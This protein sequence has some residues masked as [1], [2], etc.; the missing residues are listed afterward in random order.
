MDVLNAAI[1]DAHVDACVD[2]ANHHDC[3]LGTL[4]VKT[5]VRLSKSVVPWHVLLLR[6]GWVGVLALK[7]KLP[8][9][10]R[11][12]DST[13]ELKPALMKKAVE[14]LNLAIRA[15]ATVE[16]TEILD[17]NKSLVSEEAADLIQQYRMSFAAQLIEYHAICIM[18]SRKAPPSRDGAG[19][20]GGGVPASAVLAHGAGTGMS[21]LLE[22]FTNQSGYTMAVKDRP[23][24]AGVR[25]VTGV[26]ELYPPTLPGVL[27]V[28]RITGK[29]LFTSQS[30]RIFELYVEILALSS[31]GPVGVP[32]LQRIVKSDVH[33]EIPQIDTATGR[34]IRVSCTLA[35][36]PKFKKVIRD[37][38][39][40]AV[41]SGFLAESKVLEVCVAVGNDLA[42]FI[43]KANVFLSQRCL[44]AG[45]PQRLLDEAPRAPV[46]PP[47]GS[48]RA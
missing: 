16:E 30:L 23:E 36:V 15:V 12:V 42:L 32:P 26:L 14:A 1:D 40:D 28:M 46:A 9:D 34:R 7:S 2:A 39:E 19:D 5:F 38:I 35:R 13:K 33:D 47:P 8:R 27:L 22:Y 18:G 10:V 29:I 44:R 37:A 31:Y 11:V 25:Q 24:A 48:R 45:R 6:S 20:R 43:E 4:T 41:D 17:A 3:A 21:A